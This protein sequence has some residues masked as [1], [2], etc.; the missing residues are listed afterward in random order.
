M[1]LIFIVISSGLTLGSI[2][3]YLRDV[4]R[5]KT[6]PRIVSW[7]T[8]SLLTGISCV[9]LF[10]DHAYASAMLLLAD[11]I[12]TTLVVILGLRHGN[13]EFDRMDIVCQASALVGVALWLIFNSPI[14]AVAASVTIDTVGALLPTL[15]HT[16]QKPHEETMLAYALASVGAVFAIMAVTSWEATALVYPIYL[17]AMNGL[18][19]AVIVLRH[20]SVAP[21]QPVASREL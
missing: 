5:G 12:A 3:P 8:W 6:K 2:A 17:V 13:R 4:V 18:L 21:S 10:S 16:W 14:I 7:F 9:A 19:A 11:T 1:R 20:R 15:K